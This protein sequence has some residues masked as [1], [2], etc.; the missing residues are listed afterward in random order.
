MKGP[1]TTRH[2]NPLL[3]DYQFPG[4]STLA[5]K[6][7]PYSLTKVETAKAAENKASVGDDGLTDHERAL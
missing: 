1:K 3:G 6:Q 2:I 7:N 5:D 4:W